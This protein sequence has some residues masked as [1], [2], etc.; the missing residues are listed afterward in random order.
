MKP[1]P[2]QC[3]PILDILSRV[4][5]KWTMMV[6]RLLG[7]RPKRFSALKREIGGISQRMLTTTLRAL[8]RDGMVKRTVHPL[9]PPHVE[10]ELT[11]LGREILV[12]LAM[13]GEWAKRNQA[14]IAAARDAFD[15]QVVR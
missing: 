12:P 13:L 5:D 4:G 3:Q 1:P 2:R 10:Y 9:I 15:D 11:D 7:E 14:R 6:V 8:E